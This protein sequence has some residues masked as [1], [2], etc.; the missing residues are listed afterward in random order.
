MTE[1]LKLTAVV[2]APPERVAEVLLAVRPDGV[3]GDEFVITDRG[4]RITVTVDRA[5]RSVS[6]QG[7]WW[8]RGVTSVEPDPRGSRVVHRIFNVAPKNGWAVRFVSRGPLN[9]AP[10][11]FA[12][13]VRD[14]GEQ[15]GVK[16]WVID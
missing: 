4:S 3:T 15:L 7:E 12:E 6:R 13:T 2:E 1:L 9:A 11:S 8:Y 14:L 10:A 5:A 16:A